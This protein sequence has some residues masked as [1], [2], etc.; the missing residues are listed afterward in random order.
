MFEPPCILE[1]RRLH[2]S[3]LRHG[4]H[5]PAKGLECADFGQRQLASAG[6]IGVAT[7]RRQWQAVVPWQPDR[8]AGWIHHPV[9][10]DQNPRH[11]HGT[12]AGRRDSAGRSGCGVHGR[13]GQSQVRDGPQRR[14]RRQCGWGG[15][16]ALESGCGA[17]H[18]HRHHRLQGRRHG[19][20]CHPRRARRQ[21]QVAHVD[22]APPQALWG[23]LWR[24]ARRRLRRRGHGAVLF[25]NGSTSGH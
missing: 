1:F 17:T 13:C 10:L 19:V 23:R 5:R 24:R 6:S 20:L 8:A 3:H 11:H 12:G 9:Q 4:N 14:I 21:V 2:D 25:R 18:G 22:R 7:S 16:A 15:V